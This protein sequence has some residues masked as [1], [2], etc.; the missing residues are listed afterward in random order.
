MELRKCRLDGLYDLVAP[1]LS[2]SRGYMQK[3]YD[4]RGFASAYG[5]D[6]VWRQ[7]IVSHTAKVGTLRGLYVQRAPHTEGKAVVCLRGRMWWVVVDLRR[8]SPTFG[9]WEGSDLAPG[10]GIFIE[11]GFAHG[12]IALAD[13]TDLLLMADNDHS[14]TSGIGLLWNDPELAIDWPLP[15]GAPTLSAAHAA[16]LSFSDFKA[17]HGAV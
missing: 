15:S 7:I 9:M 3:P 11:P 12:C 1:R 17:R 2:D 10:Q 13:D 4:S 16:G 8:A 14:D 5:T 6:K